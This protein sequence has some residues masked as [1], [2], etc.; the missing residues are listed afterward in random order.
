MKA[1]IYS[2]VG[3]FALVGYGMSHLPAEMMYEIG[4]II[5]VCII[6]LPA[7]YGMWRAYGMRGIWVMVVLGIFSL[8]IET[9]GL[10]T[11][12]P[13]SSFEYVA[14]F[15]YRL[16]ETTPWTVFVAWSPLVIGAYAL[17]HRWFQKSWSR[18][19]VYLG[20]LVSFDL[21]L[22]PGAVAQGLW[23]YSGGG[24]WYGVPIENFLG[25]IFSGVIAYG[26]IQLMTRNVPQQK[27]NFYL[28]IPA[29]ATLALWSGVTFGYGIILPAVT[30]ILLLIIILYGIHKKPSRS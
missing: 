24:A 21:V 12:F 19:L 17:S 29:L 8:S 26:I 10:H 15:G 27:F 3:I 7:F 14:E 4:S 13:Y 6:A 16:F 5:A 22:D 11:G 25:W 2:I 23:E 28:I 18:L 1:I 30:G 20:L 9:I